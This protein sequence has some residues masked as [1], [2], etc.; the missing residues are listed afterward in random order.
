MVYH[1]FIFCII[2]FIGD[3]MLYPLILTSLA[4][5]ATLIGIIPIF[6]KIKNKDLL[7]SA[8][9]AF[10]SGVMICISIFDLIP[11]SIKYLSNYLNSFFTI[12]FSFIFILVGIIISMI[13]DN[14]IDRVSKEDSLFKVGVLSMIAIILHNIPEGIV[15]FIV[16]N[17]NL[18]LGLSICIAIALHNIPEGISIAIPIYHSTNSKKRAF[19]YTFIASLSE[20][21]GAI[22][23]GLFLINYVNDFVLG[24]L[25]SFIAGIMIQI[26]SCKL[27]PTGNNYNKKYS[28]IFFI[29][30][31]IIMLFSLQ[32]E[33]LVS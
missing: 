11:E 14:Y 25:F 31:F 28:F 12:S 18:M 33:N 27:L 32:L 15:T 6:V 10:A 9:C 24:L 4:G 30:G 21:L 19:L 29:I 17:K 1:I 8:A 20:P 7:I 5:L 26:S 2:L 3:Y 23:T 22:L 13:L 16:S